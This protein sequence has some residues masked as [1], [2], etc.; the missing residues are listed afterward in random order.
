[1]DWDSPATKKHIKEAEAQGCKLVGD[2]KNSNYRL[3]KLECDHEQQLK[4]SHMR[5]GTFKCRACIEER[6]SREAQKH[7]CE[8]LGPGARAPYRRYRLPCGHE[9]E[10]QPANLTGT[11]FR[12]RDCMD[13]E[14]RKDAEKQKCEIL[15]NGKNS[16]YRLYRLDCGHKRE[17]RVDDMRTG[18]FHC[19]DCM[20]E[21]LRKDAEKH[22]CEL[23]GAGKNSNYRL[24]KLECGHKREVKTGHMH[25]GNFR[26]EECFE[27]KLNREA[28]ANDCELLRPGRNFNYRWYKLL[29]CGHEQELTTA[30]VRKGEFACKTCLAERLKQEA[31]TQEIELIGPGK[32]HHYRLYKLDCGHE[33]ELLTQKVRDGSFRCDICLA[34]RLKHE[35]NAQGAELLGPGST[36]SHRI[37]E[38]RCGHQQEVETGNM[39]RGN[40]GCIVCQEEKVRSEARALG[41]EII[42]PGRNANYRLYKLLCGHEREVKVD[43][44]RNNSFV[45]QTCEDTS[46]TLP[47]N[48]YL[49]YIKVGYDEWLKLGYAKSVTHRTSQYGLPASAEVTTVKSLPF[50]TGNEAHAAEADIHKRYRRKRLTKKQ[51]ADFHTASGFDECY[52][53]TMLETLLAELETVKQAQARKDQA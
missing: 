39:R 10:M 1:M 17:V 52:P 34:N 20:D 26:C 23:L 15:G 41:C 37:Y 7:K 38:L 16:N 50:D 28:T 32:T 46:R 12:C 24:Y 22:K 4:L 2:G 49:L 11:K 19:R 18:S 3:Y 31:E 8:L 9:Q 27:D 44:M 13:D 6:F 30:N 35:A 5:K 45:C 53:V 25:D 47:S 42:G 21:E 36:S 43:A 51:M 40:I 48:L 33:R 14:L 29:R